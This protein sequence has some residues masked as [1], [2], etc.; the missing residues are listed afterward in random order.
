MVSRSQTKELNPTR[1]YRYDVFTCAP[2]EPNSF[3]SPQ[4]SAQAGNAAMRWTTACHSREVQRDPWMRGYI[5]VT[6]SRRYGPDVQ[7]FFCGQPSHCR[8]RGAIEVAL[9]LASASAKR[10]HIS[11]GAV[12]GILCW[13]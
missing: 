9:T 8:L 1:I 12:V 2:G 3:V 5:V 4:V 13:S 10:E 6:N 7:R 11:L